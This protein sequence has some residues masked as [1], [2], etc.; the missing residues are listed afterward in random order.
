MALNKTTDHR[1]QVGFNKAG[2]IMNIAGLPL[3]FFGHN[4]L[5]MI[6]LDVAINSQDM[7]LLETNTWM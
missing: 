6:T 3:Y 1:D 5:D 2:S 4:Y 7:F